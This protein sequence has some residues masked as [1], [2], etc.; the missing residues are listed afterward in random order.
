MSRSWTTVAAVL[1]VLLVSG[2]C[3]SNTGTV[4]LLNNAEEPISRV[5]LT[6]SWGETLEATDLDPSEVATINYRVREGEYQ[7]AVVFRS[8]KRLK[9]DGG[10]YIASGVDYQDQITVTSSEIQV[11][12]KAVARR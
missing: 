10:Y 5:T 6:M 7:V 9:T 11:T 8:G 4:S 2:S 1:I 3:S 12:H